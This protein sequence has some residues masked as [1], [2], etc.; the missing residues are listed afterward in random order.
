M[1]WKGRRKSG[2]V[3]DRRGSS[4]GKIA[5]GGGI[6]AVIFIAIQLFTGGD[7]TDI[8]NQFQEQVPASETREL[9]A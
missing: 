8:L 6:I 7:A 4:K 5:A 1:K 2:N 3:E 9:T